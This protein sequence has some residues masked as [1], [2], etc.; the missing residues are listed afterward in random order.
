M[1]RKKGKSYHHTLLLRYAYPADDLTNF[2]SNSNPSSLPPRLHGLSAVLHHL[3]GAGHHGDFTMIAYH[4]IAS[5]CPKAS[6]ARRASNLTPPHVS[7]GW[8]PTFHG[9]H[10]SSFGPEHQRRRG[11]GGVRR[12]CLASLEVPRRICSVSGEGTCTG[13]PIH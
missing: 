11:D 7:S 8:R 4:T 5:G 13:D 3:G 6:L 2:S 12:A 10:P 9:M 1:R